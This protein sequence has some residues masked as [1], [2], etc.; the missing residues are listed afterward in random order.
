MFAQLTKSGEAN[1]DWSSI[2]CF[3][4]R[5]ASDTSTFVKSFVHGQNIK[6]KAGYMIYTQTGTGAST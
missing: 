1:V 2:S 6:F 3:N 4:M 5:S